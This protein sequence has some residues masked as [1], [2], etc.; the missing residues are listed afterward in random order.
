MLFG[1]VL[2]DCSYLTDEHFPNWVPQN[3]SSVVCSKC[4]MNK[5]PTVK[6][7]C[8]RWD[9]LTSEVCLFTA[10]LMGTVFMLR[11]P[12]W[13]SEMAGWSDLLAVFTEQWECRP[14]LFI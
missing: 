9:I 2:Q 4:S 8:K 12:P 7:V 11:S 3:I 10:R 5:S 6:Y 14:Y 1:F 13:I